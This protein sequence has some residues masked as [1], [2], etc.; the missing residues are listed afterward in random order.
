MIG[1]TCSISFYFWH[2]YYQKLIDIPN[3]VDSYRAKLDLAVLPTINHKIYKLQIVKL[4]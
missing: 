1:H 3:V 2:D 4:F